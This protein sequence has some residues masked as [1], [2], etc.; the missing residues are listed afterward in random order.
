MTITNMPRFTA[1][2]SLYKTSA[3]Y[4]M[5]A[6]LDLQNV[7]GVF[8][9]LKSIGFC[10]AD[11]DYTNSDPFM[12]T[13]CKMGCLDQGG[14]G[15]PSGPSTEHCQPGCGPCIDGSKLCVKYDCQ[16]VERVCP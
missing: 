4:R 9:Q 2:A 3:R 8:P 16:T 6:T 10:M 11:C 15:E 7:P 1:E 13:I 12:S 14:G 5:A